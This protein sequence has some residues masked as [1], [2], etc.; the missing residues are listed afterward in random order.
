MDLPRMFLKR[1]TLEFLDLIQ[2]II[3]QPTQGS[4]RTK[5]CKKGKLTVSFW[6]GPSIIQ[7][8]LSFSI[9]I[10]GC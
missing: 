10:T 2:I 3:I 8:F 7:S 6:A 9:G 1:I 5:I 4:S